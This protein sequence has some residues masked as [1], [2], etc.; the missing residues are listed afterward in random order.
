MQTADKIWAETEKQNDRDQTLSSDH[1]AKHYKTA[2]HVRGRVRTFDSFA[3][4]GV[5]TAR[6]GKSETRAFDAILI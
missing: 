4:I 1:E 3:C 2:V 5:S 6:G